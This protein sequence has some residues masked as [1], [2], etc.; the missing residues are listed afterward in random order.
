MPKPGDCNLSSMFGIIFLFLVILWK[1]CG[2]IGFESRTIENKVNWSMGMLA[3]CNNHLFLNVVIWKQALGSG[4]LWTMHFHH[5]ILQTSKVESLDFL[6]LKSRYDLTLISFC[7]QR[8]AHEISY[9]QTSKLN[10][11][12]FNKKTRILNT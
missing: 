1:A 12:N 8:Y 2:W 9:I 5:L 4:I 3:T 11:L 6:I 7:F 10:F